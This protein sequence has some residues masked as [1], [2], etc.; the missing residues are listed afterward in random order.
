MGKPVSKASQ[1]SRSPVHVVY[2]G[3]DRYSA[4]TPRKLG[5]IALAT[6]QRYAPGF[7]EFAEACYLPGSEAL[8][9]YPEA[10]AKLDQEMGKG[11][12]NA[13]AENP[14][15][16]FA[17][18]VYRKTLEKLAREAVEDFR[19]DFEDGY[20]FRSD[21]EEDRDAVITATDL[22]AAYR[23]GSITPFCGFRI[24]SLGRETS[25]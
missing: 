24:K 13:A 8:P 22:G 23:K 18:T 5:Q 9:T 2:G 6:M 15:A 16:W 11:S 20:G 7:V 3:A 25:K 12:S 10:V 21:E 19:I 14:A 1:G 4:N 17:W